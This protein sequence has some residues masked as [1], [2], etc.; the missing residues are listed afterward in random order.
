MLLT[1]LDAKLL[2]FEHI[3]ELYAHDYDFSNIYNAYEK[4]A[5]YKFYR[6]NWYLF[7]L[8]KHCVPKCSL[9]LMLICKVYEGGLMGHFSIAK[10][11]DILQEHFFWPNMK[12]D[13]YKY[14]ANCITYLQA[15]SKVHP[16]GLYTPLPV[17]Y[18]PWVDVSMD[19]VLGL[20]RTRHSND[21]IYM[22]VDRF[23]KMAH[24]ISC[25]KTDDASYVTDLFFRDVV[26]LHGIPRTIVSNRD[27]KF[28]SYF[29][30]TLWAKL[31]TKLLFSTTCH[32]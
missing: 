5:F 32:P 24:F 11:L 3:K 8:N 22:V 14:C 23:F 1:T 17:P 25:H 7:R 31:G 20:P 4:V 19:F 30:K 29:W 6:H 2:G 16:Y 27:A 18:L 9:Y 21:N 13:V 26:C 15:K 12:F 28:L 10:T